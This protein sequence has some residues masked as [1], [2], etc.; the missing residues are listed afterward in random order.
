MGTK[1][2]LKKLGKYL[3]NAD[4]DDHEHCDQLDELLDKIRKKE[5]KLKSKLE[6][7]RDPEERKHLKTELKIVALQLKRGMARRE[8]L[9]K[10]CGK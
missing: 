1:K 4:M 9:G 2:L 8:E 5:Q 6:G 7:E 3:D 10:Q